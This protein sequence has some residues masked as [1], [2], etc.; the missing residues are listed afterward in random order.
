MC[1]YKKMFTVHMNASQE[2]IH[3]AHEGVTG[4][5]FE[6]K[7]LSQHKQHCSLKYNC[8]HD[9]CSLYLLFLLHYI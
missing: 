2:T 4:Y 6:S 8:F 3:E 1:I 9:T 5:P 7:V